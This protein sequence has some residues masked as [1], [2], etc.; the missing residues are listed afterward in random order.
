MDRASGGG[1]LVVGI[2][3][4]RLEPGERRLLGRLAPYGVI[5]FAR[6]VETAAQLA[7]LTADL[8]RAAPGALLFVDAEGGRVDRLRGVVGPAP[9][10]AALA[11]SPPA[12]AAR[13][14]RWIGAALR[15]FD[16][17]ATYAP[18]VDLDRGATGNALDG[19]CF[20]ARPRPVI[21]RA[22]AFLRG[23]HAAGAGGCLKHYPGLGG[24][25]EDTHHRGSTGTLTLEELE[26]DLAPFAALGEAA[27]AV[28]VGHADYPA[29][30]PSRRPATLSAEISGR[31]LRGRLGFGGV[32]FS[33]DL[34]MK[35]L[36]PWGGMPELAAQSLAAGCDAVL[37]CS[38]LEE[39]P[40]VA[41]RL[42]SP[43]LAAARRRALTR[44]AGY[45]DH[46]AAHRR[47]ARRL[48]PEAVAKRLAAL[49]EAV[50]R[51]GA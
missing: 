30:D 24:A 11:A 21:A 26:D 36:A 19:R 16:L 47:A 29:L 3:G 7:G 41:D 14:G 12:L 13:A 1:L 25:A 42:S 48:P 23:L 27:G 37:V 43:P 2:G 33:D 5:L 28:M 6:N 32:A 34:E 45:R 44:L 20:G 18:V 31:L 22:R 10:G 9:S 49:R 4:P 35:A 51:A 38:R 8:R 46:L 15:A 40:A 50:D 17:D 39:A